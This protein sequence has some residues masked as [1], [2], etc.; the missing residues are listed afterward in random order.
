M[1]KNEIVYFNIEIACVA[2]VKAAVILEKMK[3]LEAK[4]KFVTL[5]NLYE[6]IVFMTP[7]VIQ[8]NCEKLREHNLIEYKKSSPRQVKALVLNADIGNMKVCEWCGGKSI[9]LQK[10]HYPVPK[11]KGGTETVNV[12]PNCHYGFHYLENQLRVVK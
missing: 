10:H 7:R 8:D 9:V 3:E 5:D 4:G 1:R 12:C 2:G 6:T 11:A